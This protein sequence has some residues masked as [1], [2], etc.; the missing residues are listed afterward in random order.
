VSNMAGSSL[1]L[2]GSGDIPSG[3]WWQFRTSSSST[4]AVVLAE[5]KH[6]VIRCELQNRPD[7]SAGKELDACKTLQVK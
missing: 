5:G 1:K 6:G 7:E 2:E 4:F 3:K